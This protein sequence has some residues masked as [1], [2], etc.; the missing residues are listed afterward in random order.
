MK[1]VFQFITK[2]I[3]PKIQGFLVLEE[4]EKRGEKRGKRGEK[5]REE[6]KERKEGGSHEY[7]E[8]KRLIFLGG[9]EGRG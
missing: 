3:L 4:G 5:R 7:F 2:T 6:K 8:R 9:G 1:Q